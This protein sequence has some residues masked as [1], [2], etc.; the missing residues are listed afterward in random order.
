MNFLKLINWSIYDW[1][2][3]EHQRDW[4]GIGFEL[5]IW[6]FRLSIIFLRL[7]RDYR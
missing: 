1:V 2:D 3:T 6:K 7:E 4:R 5:T